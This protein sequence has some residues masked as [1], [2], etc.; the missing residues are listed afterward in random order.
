MPIV[1]EKKRINQK[2]NPQPQRNPRG[3][4]SA[5]KIGGQWYARKRK[6][7]FP[8]RFGT[9]K[10]TKGE[11]YGDLPNVLCP[12]VPLP[13]P[14]TVVP[15]IPA[16]SAFFRDF[17]LEML[18]GKRRRHV[19]ESTWSTDETY[20][21]T[22]VWTSDLGKT[23]LDKVTLE[24]CQKFVDGLIF[25]SKAYRDRDEAGK[26][27]DTYHLV[28][29]DDLLMPASVRKIGAI[30][31]RYLQLAVAAKLLKANPMDGVE[32]PTN[33]NKGKASVLPP[34]VA[35]CLAEKLDAWNSGIRKQGDRDRAMILV[36]RDTGMRRAGVCGLR[37]DRVHWS[38][39]G[40]YIEIS[41][42]VVRKKGG[43]REKGTKTGDV[44]EI[45]I[46]EETYDL[47]RAQ[48]R[49]GTYVFTTASGR[50]VRPD[51]LTRAFRN[52]ATTL[53]IP[54]LHLHNLRHTYISMLL[55]AGVDIKTVQKMVG[56]RTPDMIMKVYAQI[57]DESQR[58]GV[59]KLHLYMER[60]RKTA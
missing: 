29:L 8:D 53:D 55:R 58:E 21:R 31:H 20:W 1:E 59:R 32:Y 38:P 4:G 47:I 35:A 51:D 26:L 23:P 6:K 12:S 44:H 10:P 30:V 50:A 19:D 17:M 18:E 9:A 5:V 7:G 60:A 36:A 22:R 56:H 42:T 14:V 27:L 11:A 40:P 48:P 52:F 28:F 34:A 41:R 46:S 49:R 13:A 37:W 15:E 16:T 43:L 57:F 25:K 33:E 2:K 45:P 3:S 39:E 24:I 54:G